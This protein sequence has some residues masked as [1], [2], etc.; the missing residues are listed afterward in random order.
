MPVMS[1]YIMVVYLLKKI[2]VPPPLLGLYTPV[3]ASSSIL[4][5]CVYQMSPFLGKWAPLMYQCSIEKT[6]LIH[7]VKEEGPSFLPESI[8]GIS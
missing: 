4:D 8:T 5:P 3:S 7:P 2:I 6:D 1:V